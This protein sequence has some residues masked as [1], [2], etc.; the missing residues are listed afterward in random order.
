MSRIIISVIAFFLCFSQMSLISAEELGKEKRNDIEQLLAVTGALAIGQQMSDAVVIQMSEALKASRP[1]LPP[2]LFDAMR[3]EVNG[4]IEENLAAF[5][6]LVIPLYH[7]HL[8]HEEIKGLLHFYKSDLGRR[9]I[10]VMP[11]L[12]QE[13][14]SLGLRWGQALGPEIQKRVIERF[15]LEGVDLTAS[16]SNDPFKPRQPASQA[17]A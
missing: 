14:M 2:E 9:T 8:T 17:A 3:D 15:K 1:D 5:S 12:M 10:K 4:V 11:T 13:S 7:K 16:S 6:E